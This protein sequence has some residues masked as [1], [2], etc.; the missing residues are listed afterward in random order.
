MVH[1]APNAARVKAMWTGAFRYDPDGLGSEMELKIHGTLSFGD[2]ANWVEGHVGGTVWAWVRKDFLH[3]MPPPFVP[4]EG[5]MEYIGDEEGGRF[6]LTP[7][8]GEIFD[9]AAR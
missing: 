9:I 4:F 8:D 5:K 7:L 6:V 2:L 3:S 1:A